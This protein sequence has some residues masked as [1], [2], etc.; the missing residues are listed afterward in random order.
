MLMLLKTLVIPMIE[1]GCFLWNPS[2]QSFIKK[3]KKIENVQQCF[4]LKISEMK[5]INYWDRCSP[6]IIPSF[7]NRYIILYTYKSILAKFQ[8]QNCSGI[9]TH[10]KA[11]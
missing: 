11:E 10:E 5:S 3:K 8:I 6:R 9:S 4:T 7:R 1:Y 2:E